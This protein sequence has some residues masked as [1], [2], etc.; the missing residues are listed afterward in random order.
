MAI[1][2]VVDASE[3]GGLER[4]GIA[5]DDDHKK[6]DEFGYT[7]SILAGFRCLPVAGPSADNIF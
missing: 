5:F 4:Y 7:M 6:I 1:R 2:S 3:E